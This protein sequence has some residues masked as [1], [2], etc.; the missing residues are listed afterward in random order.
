MTKTNG[1]DTRKHHYSMFMLRD[2]L[3][4]DVICGQKVICRFGTHC[5][6]LPKKF[7]L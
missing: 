3:S 4:F 2:Y 6:E 5:T 7:M 1:S